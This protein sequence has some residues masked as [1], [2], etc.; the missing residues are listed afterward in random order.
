MF[1]R[2]V[3]RPIATEDWRIMLFYR[4]ARLDSESDRHCVKPMSLVLSCWLVCLGSVGASFVWCVG[5]RVF[6]FWFRW[7][8]GR[9]EG[10][11][12]RLQLAAVVAKRGQVAG[13]VQDGAGI[14]DEGSRSGLCCDTVGVLGQQILQ[15]PDKVRM[16][17]GDVVFL[18]EVR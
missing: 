4:A 13:L 16:I 10:K 2:D 1:D 12:G 9:H 11:R 6:G 8:F 3:H 18:A 15:L 7:P 5:A 14:V 17:F